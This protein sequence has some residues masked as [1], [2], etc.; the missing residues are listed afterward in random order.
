MKETLFMRQL[1]I[2]FEDFL[3]VNQKRSKHTIA[4][5]SHSFALFFKFLHEAKNMPHYLVDYKHLTVQLFDEF[6]AWLEKERNCSAATK[7]ARMSAITSFLK[8][9][10]RREMAALKACNAAMVMGLPRVAHNSFPYFTVEEIR[11]ILNLPDART[12]LGGRDL[13]LLSL[14]YD[15]AARA[16]ELCDLCVDD[17]KFGNPTKV[18][19]LGKGK[20][21]REVPVS[22]E[23][24]RLVKYH[25][26]RNGLEKK[27]PLFSSQTREKMT[28][29]CMRNL[30]N[31]YVKIA[32]QK[33]PAL[34]NEP[35]YSPH[36]FRHSKAIHMLEAGT[37]LVYIRNFLGHSSIQSTEVYARVNHQAVEKALANR[38]IP[39]L[40]PSNAPA[41]AEYVALPTFLI[42]QR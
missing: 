33:H 25:I 41:N 34:F 12:R 37:A 21:M 1:G 32:K 30:T 8:Y 6:L 29:A 10:S 17:I 9:A 11:I 13:V 42:A 31:K 16:Q 28:V 39:R 7:R 22:E 5:Y 14:L 3:P 26:Q 15:S 19:L 2:Y 27:S 23:V 36:S 38:K 4:A 20:K 40:S 18:K 35:K 24:A